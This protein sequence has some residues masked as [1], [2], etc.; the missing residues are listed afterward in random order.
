MSKDVV[1]LK[2]FLNMGMSFLSYATN[3]T[4]EYNSNDESIYMLEFEEIWEDVE[5]LFGS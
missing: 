1:S 4:S 3:N 2:F 5:T